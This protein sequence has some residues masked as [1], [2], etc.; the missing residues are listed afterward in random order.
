VGPIRCLP[1]VLLALLL[2]PARDT[3]GDDAAPAADPFRQKRLE[4]LQSRVAELHFKSDEQELQRG[5]QPVL[6]WSNPVRDF[7]NDG[8][9]FLFLDGERPRAIVNSRVRG[10]EAP[11]AS[12]ELLHEFASLSAQPLLCRRNDRTI[13]SPKAGALVEQALPKSPAPAA[14]PVQR[15]AQMREQAARFVAASQKSGSPTKLRLLTQPLYR[16]QDKTAG[17]GDGALFAFVEGNDPEAILL[18]EAAAGDGGKPATWRYTL[19]RMTFYSVVVELDD[20]EV[21]K[22]EPILQTKDETA[23]Y[24]EISDGAF[25]L[26]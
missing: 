14:R 1:L 2:A 4:L 21:I 23:P 26:E 12:G 20:R 3:F 18:L 16:Y 8:V 11:L 10:R 17:I 15:L 22:F 6:R 25:R 24:L 7:V 9:A 19:A 13:W 5:K